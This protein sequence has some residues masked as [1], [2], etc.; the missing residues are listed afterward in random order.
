LPG[1]W[2][3]HLE[4][5][6]A[7]GVVDAATASR[8]RA[9]EQSHGSNERLRWPVMLALALGGLLLCAG[10]LLFVAAHWE[11]LSPGQRFSLVLFL[12][13]IFPASG[14]LTAERFPAL[15]VT[16]HAVG[17]ITVGA[18][19][20][21]A[22]QIFNLEENWANG[23]LLW[24]IGALIGA[25][26]LRQW[27][28]WTLLAIL[29][30]MWLAGEWEVRAPLQYG[31]D[32]TVVLLG[33]LLLAITYVSARSGEEDAAW[34][35]GLVWVGSVA[36]LPCAVLAFV[37]RIE[38]WNRYG[39]TKVSPGLQTTAWAIAIAGPLVL[40]VVMRGRT[41][42]WNALFA[43][44]VLVI[45]TFHPRYAAGSNSA[46]SFAWN[47][48]GTFFWAALGALGLVA[49]GVMERRRERINLGVAGFALTVVIFYFSNVMD[50]LGRSASLI[51][52]GVIFLVGGWSLEKLRRKLIGQI[53]EQNA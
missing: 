6:M 2:E 19:I 17:T 52:M 35:R 24:A 23:V 21:L 18:G 30:P 49:W 47:N 43:V 34:R 13:A 48:L 15:A 3:R 22:A 28:Q 32:Y 51:G 29:T 11:Q 33:L 26:L 38:Q 46:A 31:N 41:A 5:W 14:A 20:F 42:W 45:V 50:K 53:R 10:V 9:F 4:R 39:A 36:L 25:L 12:V 37:A 16:L 40:A 1:E 44:W 27:P 7:A 8:I